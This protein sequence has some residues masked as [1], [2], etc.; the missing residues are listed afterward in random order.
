M[1]NKKFRELQKYRNIESPVKR[2]A[3]IYMVSKKTICENSITYKFLSERCHTT[4]SSIRHGI[5]TINEFWTVGVCSRPPLL[6]KANKENLEEWINLKLNDN[7]IISFCEY[8]EAI[9]EE[10]R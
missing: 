9:L 8:C 6:T 10:I 3:T 5:S 7:T 4:K 1:D 2:A